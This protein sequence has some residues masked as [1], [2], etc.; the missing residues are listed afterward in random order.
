MPNPS[1]RSI[2]AS[3]FKARC[4]ELMDEV[5]ATRAELVITKHGTA[6]ARLVPVDDSAASALGFLRGT[7]RNEPALLESEVTI[8]RS[9]RRK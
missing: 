4:L 9:T 8:T 6:V 2:P 1:R 5:N 7:V 3:E